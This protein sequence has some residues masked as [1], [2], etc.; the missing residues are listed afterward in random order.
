MLSVKNITVKQL[1]QYFHLSWQADSPVQLLRD[2]EIT[3]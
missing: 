1:G 2:G 3:Q